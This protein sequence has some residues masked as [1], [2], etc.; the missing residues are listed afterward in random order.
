MDDAAILVVSNHVDELRALERVL[1]EESIGMTV[2]NSANEAV[3][4]LRRRDFVLALIDAAAPG[5]DGFAL[6]KHLRTQQRTCELP[7]ILMYDAEGDLARFDHGYETG[8]VDCLTKPVDPLSLRAKARVFADLARRRRLVEEARLETDRLVAQ[9]QAANTYKSEFVANMS[10]EIRTPMN[11]VIGMVGLLMDTPLTDE[12]RE[13]AETIRSCTD[14]LLAIVDEILDYSKVEAG[15]LDLEKLDFDLRTTLEEACDILAVRA[16][17]KGLDFTCHISP[18]VPSLLVGDPGRIRQILTNLVGN[19]TK[20]TERGEIAVD[21]SLVQEKEDAVLLR[22]SVRDTGIGIPQARIERVFDSFAQV[23]GSTAR[24]YGGTGL[25]L[26]ISKQ[27]T[28]LMGGRMGLE[29]QEG[30]GSTFWSEVWLNKQAGAVSRPPLDLMDLVGHRVL[31]VDASA[32]SRRVLR[33]LLKAWQCETAEATNGAEALQA[34]RRAAGL[35]RPFDVTILDHH[36]PAQDGVTFALEVREE[37]LVRDT[38]LVLLTARGQRGDAERM[39]TAGFAGYVTKPVRH[40]QLHDILAVVLGMRANE[41]AEGAAPL[42]T[43]HWLRDRQRQQVRILLAEDNVVNQRVAS[44]ILAKLGYEADLAETGVMAV[45]AALRVDYDLILMDC[46]MPEMDGLEATR[47][48]RRRTEAGH[49]PSIVAMTAFA[50][51]SDRDACLQ[52]GM[53]GY[54]SKPVK[55]E[56]LAEAVERALR[57]RAR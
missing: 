19:A 42:V 38:A 18:D 22:L 5:V 57:E 13:Y 20:F 15:K 35:G 39:G 7:F 56:E 33:D 32:S 47:V 21:V 2:A 1:R 46:Q 29:S 49:R 17:E 44:K 31:I 52:A 4:A 28:E 45:D 40:R 25:G 50:M 30:R 9:A 26:A 3:L 12:Q 16:F 51:N 27:L 53:D 43:K 34:L 54:I 24:L 37:P 23:D 41:A 36:L 14:A 55:P 11:G 10:H 48:I 6:T 8:A